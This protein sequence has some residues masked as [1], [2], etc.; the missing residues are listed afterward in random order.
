VTQTLLQFA[1]QCVAVMLLRRQKRDSADAYKMPLYP[2]PALIALSGWIYVVVT[3][4]A[5]YIELAGLFLA[6]G[7]G[8]FLIRAWQQETWPFT[9]T[10]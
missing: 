4:G 7:I 6:I 10:V 8:I 3:S 5:A 2:L 9:E 1:A